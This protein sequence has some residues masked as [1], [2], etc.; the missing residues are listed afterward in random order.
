MSRKIIPDSTFPKL[1]RPQFESQIPAHLLNDASPSDR[2]IMEKLSK[3]IQYAEWS[4]NAHI[5][6]DA[7]IRKTN[8]RLIS[9]EDE[10]DDIKTGRRIL[11]KGWKYV[12]AFVGVL[13]GILSSIVHLI[14]H[15]HHP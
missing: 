8:G 13:G 5:T 9:V 11:F 4:T 14:Q 12:V 6:H 3:L 15:M 2:F 7:C 1:E 10:V